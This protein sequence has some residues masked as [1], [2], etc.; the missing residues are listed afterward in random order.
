MILMGVGF[1]DNS[2]NPVKSDRDA[3]IE[4]VGTIDNTR[5][6]TIARAAI[7]NSIPSTLFEKPEPLS[8]ILKRFGIFERDQI[9]VGGI[10]SASYYFYNLDE[11][12]LFVIFSVKNLRKDSDDELV[13]RCGVIGKLTGSEITELLSPY[14]D[15]KLSKQETAS[16][17]RFLQ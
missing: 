1:S 7:G 4:W 17:R 12:N 10:N 13:L 3:L 6:F 8:E 11:S 2:F 9:L 5:K 14:P 15:L 16:M